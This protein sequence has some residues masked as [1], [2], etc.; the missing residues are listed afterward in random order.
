M[1][2][3]PLNFRA[4]DPV[5][6]AIMVLALVALTGMALGSVK[7]RGVGLGVAGVLFTGI[8]AGHLG[9][10]I[11]P[12]VLEFVK[13]FGLVL[14]VFTLGLQLGPG[15]FAV[16]LRQGLALNLLAIGIVALGAGT[17]VAA[18]A[19]LGLDWCLVP[20]L[21]AGATTNT[22]SLAAGQQV[23]A[24]LPGIS[25]ARIE[26]PAVAYALSYPVGIV[27]AIGAMLILKVVFG[28]R[29]QQEAEAARAAQLAAVPPLE[30]RAMVIENPNLD[31][32]RAGD[33]PGRRETGVIITRLRAANAPAVVA[34]TDAS[35]VH[36]GDTILTVG[37]RAAL[38]QFQRVV[39]RASD[40]DLLDAPGQLVSRRIVVTR[41]DA[42]GKTV[43]ELEL[44]QRFGVVVSRIGR[45]DLEMTAVPNLR[46]QFGDVLQI[47]G[48]AERLEKA[49]ALLGNSL[50]ALNETQFVPLFAGI[51][52][53]VIVGT[54]PLA[55]PGLPTALHLGMAAGPLVVA[56]LVGRIGHIGPLIWHMPASANL[57]L[58]E[59][60]IVLFLACVGLT[61]G[62]RFFE[63]VFAPTGALWLLAAVLIALGPLVVV[64]VLARAWLKL[65]AVTL[66]GLLAGAS[67][68]PPALAFANALARTDAPSL[69]YATV[70]PLTMVVRIVVAQVV[71]LLLLG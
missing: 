1:P 39:G 47:V 21:F 23:L 20:G 71:V 60:G 51:L 41:R 55:L 69:A 62:K 56:I 59:L 33:I 40:E 57:A 9:Q 65:D 28:I 68:D 12:G 34:A 19:L 43:P 7:F 48:P 17:A 2:T 45:S 54:I 16:L 66:L 15:F 13:Q 4:S 35:V 30:R 10:T 63:T 49:A 36:R 53:G 32:L 5:A 26:L 42:L 58:R 8:L 37:A 25:P 6:H 14:F 44:D 29:V 11:D 38:D 18:A 64:G 27:G 61:A 70:Y 22:P 46:L 31:G 52:M 67:T 50:R 3:W 24:A